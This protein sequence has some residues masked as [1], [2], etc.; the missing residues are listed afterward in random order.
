MIKEA[1]VK[2]ASEKVALNKQLFT[3]ATS[4][5]NLKKILGLGALLPLDVLAK[6][7]PNAVIDAET[8]LTSLLKESP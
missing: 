5:D 3:H 7:V 1:M 4:A 8:G 6:K 2:D